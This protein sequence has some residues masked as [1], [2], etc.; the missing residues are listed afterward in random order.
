MKTRSINQIRMIA[1][2]FM[3][4][5][6]SIT[7]GWAIG[8]IETKG[9]NQ[10]SDTLSYRSF[11]GKI[12]DAQ[13]KN[14]LVFASVTVEDE[15]TGTITN[16]DGDFL[17]KIS[18]DSKSQNLFISFLGYYNLSYPLIKL[19][20]EGNVLELQPAIIT[21]NE[22]QVFP[23][24]PE[25]IVRAMMRRV[26]QNYANDANSMK[27]FYRESIKK[28]N[29][30]V[31]LS[32]AVVDIYKAS[33]TNNVNDRIRIFKGRKGINE[34]KMDTLLFKL[35]G[36]PVTALLLDAMKYPHILMDE[37][38]LK[39]YEFSI[40]NM[41]KIDKKLHYVIS[42][43][44]RHK[45]KDFPLYEGKFYI[46]METYALSSADFSLNMD[47]PDEAA[48]LF[49]KKKPFGAKVE[50]TIAKYSVKYLEQ[51][52]KWYFNYAI[53][54]VQFKVKWKKKWF[55][56]VYTLKSELAITDRDDQ[57]V[58]RIANRDRFKK[59]HVL[60]D[61]VGVFSDKNFWGKYNTIEPDKSIEVAIR[62]LN[63]AMSR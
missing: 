61:K 57:N 51:N 41:V 58:E 56:T 16:L 40:E 1:V 50:P 30:Y 19:E 10:D 28:R 20:A 47:K 6:T 37:E 27:G 8:L 39:D 31:G 32:E 49:I 7:S 34:R 52:G 26:G 42:F 12:I 24:S 33:Y 44:E 14:P 36:G 21:L 55:S 29:T 2:V 60:S 54:E 17:I 59:K 25:S 53:G 45:I 48:R 18:K 3:L 38:M 46:D 35:Q 15:N 11:K 4:F 9:N 22:V 43:V 5:I 23:D 63:R 13:T 62:K